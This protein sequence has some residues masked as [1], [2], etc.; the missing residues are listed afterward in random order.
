VVAAVAARAAPRTAAH[1]AR[2]SSAGGATA[3]QD[4]GQ[5]EAAHAAGLLVRSKAELW[6]CVMIH[7]GYCNAKKESLTKH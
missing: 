5:E 1:A 7:H 4:F 3:G 6:H 2:R